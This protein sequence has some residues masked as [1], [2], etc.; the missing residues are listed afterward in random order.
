MIRNELEKQIKNEAV[1]P[2]IAGE[3][4]TW[5]IVQHIISLMV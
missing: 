5:S 3:C 4:L 1:A 2:Y